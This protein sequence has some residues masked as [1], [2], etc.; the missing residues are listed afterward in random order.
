MEALHR[1]S[2]R[3]RIVSRHDE[4][5]VTVFEQLGD[6]ADRRRHD[7][8]AARHGFCNDIRDA[9]SIAVVEDAARQ[10]EHR[11]LPVGVEQCRLRHGAGESDDAI[12]AKTGD[13]C[14][15]G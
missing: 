10:T 6:P 2:R 8:K 3:H 13:L 5:V 1:V 12:E 4:S 9:V 11:R 14:A 15:E 7:R